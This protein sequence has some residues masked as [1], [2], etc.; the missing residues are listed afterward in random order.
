MTR[1]CRLLGSGW[2][3]TRIRSR[4]R[5]DVWTSGCVISPACFVKAARPICGLCPLLLHNTWVDDCAIS[6]NCSAKAACSV[7]GLCS[8]LLHNTWA[9]GYATSQ[10]CFV[11]AARPD[12]ALN[13]V[14]LFNR[15][16]RAE[17]MSWE[18][19][20]IAALLCVCCQL[21]MWIA[22]RSMAQHMG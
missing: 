20:D 21:C 9:D 10:A 1:W 15:T 12:G 6:R 22:P 3:F 19:C 2:R 13:S 16:A 18:M 4:V 11:T 14:L 5:R 17:R 8:V 7:S